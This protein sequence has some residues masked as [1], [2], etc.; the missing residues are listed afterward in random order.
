MMPIDSDM[1]GTGFFIIFLGV[2]AKKPAAYLLG[3]FISFVS[4]NAS[5]T[6]PLLSCILQES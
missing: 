2:N 1:S 5:G 3:L 6:V 4:R